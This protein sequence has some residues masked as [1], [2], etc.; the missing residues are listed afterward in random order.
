[1]PRKVINPVVKY[2]YTPP[3]TEEVLDELFDYLLDKFF[4]QNS[5]N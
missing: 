3:A 5:S 2:V 1:M 4:A